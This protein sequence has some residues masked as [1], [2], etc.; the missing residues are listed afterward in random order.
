M[1]DLNLDRMKPEKKEAKLLT[2]IEEVHDLMCLINEPTQ[3]TP[4]TSTLIDILLTN[5]PDYF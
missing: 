3:I 4:S 5:K 2:D 1:G